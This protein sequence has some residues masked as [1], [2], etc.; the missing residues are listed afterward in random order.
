L[1]PVV[2]VKLALRGILNDVKIGED[3]AMW[4]DG[5]AGTRT[6]GRSNLNHRRSVLPREFCGIQTAWRAGCIRLRWDQTGELFNL[7]D[8]ARGAGAPRV[9]IEDGLIGVA[10]AT[11]AEFLD[12]G[13][14]ERSF[15]AS[16][17]S[18]EVKSSHAD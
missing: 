9:G 4:I 15:D 16:V 7:L 3:N 18:D 17:D 1:P 12:L 10:Q 14:A 8:S 6:R 5:K 11:P 13:A 2:E